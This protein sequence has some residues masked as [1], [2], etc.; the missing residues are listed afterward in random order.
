MGCPLRLRTLSQG[1]PGSDSVGSCS[2]MCR[3]ERLTRSG[4]W[5]GRTKARPSPRRLHG[6][7]RKVESP[8][9]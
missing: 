7:F 9:L 3:E 5:K 1:T 8:R 2:G 6:P 4:H